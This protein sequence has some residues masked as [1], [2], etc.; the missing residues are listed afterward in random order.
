MKILHLFY[1][2]LAF[3]LSI[4]CSASP[5]EERDIENSAKLN[6]NDTQN[7][8]VVTSEISDK[9]EA[10]SDKDIALE[11][12]QPDE[13]P[14][15]AEDMSSK[16]VPVDDPVSTTVSPTTDT[17][18]QIQQEELTSSIILDAEESESPSQESAQDEAELSPVNDEETK[19]IQAVSH[20]IWD[21][22]LQKYVSSSGVVNYAGIQGSE[23][24]LDKYLNLISEQ[25]PQENWS[26]NEKLAFWINAYNAYTVKLILDHYPLKS[27]RD[28]EKPWDTSFITI[29]GK[30]YS[31]NQIEHD[32]IRPTFKEPRIHFALVCAAKSC[33]PLLNRAYTADQLNSQLDKQTRSFLNNQTFNKISEGSLT[34][35]S[36]F[37][38]YKEDF[39]IDGSV[40]NFINPYVDPNIN[41]DASI[42]YMDYNWDLNN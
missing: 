36:L 6:M 5:K 26:K 19:E 12:H 2:C 10:I 16:K 23:S 35:S 13:S 38:W 25:A 31:L 21:G 14:E 8:A 32:V 40:I 29:G 24:E 17:A 18:G 20:Q 15:N 7:E 39:L 1:L 28:I 9:S 4:A 37:D 22:L 27:I 34:V 42:S 3:T 11:Q 41:S 33:P 30:S